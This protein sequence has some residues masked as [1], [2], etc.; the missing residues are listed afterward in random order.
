MNITEQLESALR[1]TVS[2]LEDYPEETFNTK[3]ET[4]GWSGA[5]AGRHLYLSEKDM[6]QLLATAAPATDRNPEER[7]AEFESIL[8][9][10]DRKM[11]APPFLVPEEKRYDKSELIQSLEHLIDPILEAV[12]NNDLTQV[13][14]LGEGHPLNGSTKLELV[15]FAV[16]HTIRHNRQIEKLKEQV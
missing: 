11:D 15:H 4:G 1:R 13:P 16:Y 12:R 7:A 10:F 5:Q 14:D 2:L 8:L 9:D 3:P 6:A